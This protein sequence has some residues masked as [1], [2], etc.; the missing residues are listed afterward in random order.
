MPIDVSLRCSHAADLAASM[1]AFPR[2]TCRLATEY[3][4]A[5]KPRGAAEVEG[6]I[7]RLAGSQFQSAPV[8]VSDCFGQGEPLRARADDFVSCEIIAR[9]SISNAPYPRVHRTA[10][11]PRGQQLVLLAVLCGAVALA[12]AAPY[13]QTVS[14]YFL[15][16]DFGLV[17]AFHHQDALNFLSLFT[18]SWDAGVYGDVPDEI[19]PLVALSY[20]VDFFL[21]SG[22]PV[23]FHISNIVYHV[24]NS[25][26]VLCIARVLGR[27]SWPGAALSCTFFAVMPTHA[28]TVSWISGRADSI[29]ALF[30][31]G[32][33]LGFGIWRRYGA[34]WAYAAALGCCFLALFSKQYAITLPL[35]VA[36]YDLVL[37][38]RL[39]RPTWA[40]VR[41]YVPF[42]VLTVLYLG[43]RYYLFGNALR[44]NVMAP[45][46]LAVALVNTVANQ[47]EIL[48][49]GSFVL[50]DLPA[51]VRKVLRALVALT[52]ALAVLPALWDL[53]RKTRSVPPGDSMTSRLV[54]FGPVWWL[55]NV[56]P[57]AVTYATSRHL[58]L[59]AVG[60]AVVVGIAF[61]AICRRAGARQQ[62]AQPLLAAAALGACVIGLLGPIGE[63]TASASISE[64][65]AREMQA[66][67]R[68]AAAGSLIV[69]GAS[70]TAEISPR[71]PSRS[72]ANISPTP[73]QP[74]LW[75]WAIPYVHQAPFAPDE[76]TSRV[77]FVAPLLIDCCGPE[78]WFARSVATIAA[79]ASRPDP[80]PLVV[81]A[82][83]PTTGALVR[84]SDADAPCLLDRMTVM[85]AASSPEDL[86][87]GIGDLVR[88]VGRG[89][90]CE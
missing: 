71:S 12:A 32:S 6:R 59:P 85:A 20:Q 37:E 27:L 8:R 2:R 77:G 11:K 66:E 60:L 52:I 74:W 13:V 53:R 40:Y 54:F 43:L 35:L 5:E 9:D 18:R 39:A 15:G 4:C 16:D 73:G 41:P 24:L 29:P 69:L 87:R 55:I 42:V 89:Q 79:W 58:Y 45:D 19:R 80:A 22:L 10:V 64:K 33:I 57:L 70:R 1:W 86:D 26:W 65:M 67:A 17:W 51:S 47:V 28:E 3:F 81:L 90:P 88:G 38:H 82:W 23:S 84:Y 25:L 72:L 49:F 68:G 56:P 44:E 78:Q 50:E 31:V 36:A 63:W 61:D 83:R 14:N 21:G 75:S 34:A 46:R 48:F 7:R 62:L 76:I 30:Y